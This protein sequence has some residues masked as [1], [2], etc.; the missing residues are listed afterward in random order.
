M[1]EK[2]TELDLAIKCCRSSFI[3]VGIFSLCINLLM[4]VPA[5]YMLQVY[6]R[7]IASGS[8]ST[9]LM[10]TLI[11]V[12]LL[13]TMGILEWVRSSIMQKVSNRLNHQ[14]SPK[15]FDVSYRQALY[16]GGT[17]VSSQPLKDLNGIRQFLSSN[18][19]FAFFDS[20]W[21]PVYIFILYL[22]HPWIGSM[23][24]GSVIILT[25][26]ALLNEKVTQSAQAAANKELTQAANSV[27]KN[28]HNAEV[29]ESMG[30]LSHIR[31]RWSVKNKSAQAF[32][33]LAN[34]R[35]AILSSVSKTF[36]IIIQSLVLGLG[37]YLALQQAIS[38]GMMIAGSILLGRALA[39]IDQMIGV[40]KHF[41]T[42]REQYARLHN[43][44]ETDIGPHEQ[45]SLPEPIGEITAEN[46]VICAPGSRVPILKGLSFYV[47]PG[48]MIGV[49]GPSAAGKSTFARAL[50]GI[51]PALSGKI[52]LDGADIFTWDREELGPHIGYLPQDIELFEGTISDNIARFGKADPK[53]V[54]TA[55]RLAGVHDMILRLPDGYDT[56]ISTQGGTLSGG[57][58]QRIG[59]ARA[60]YGKPKFV[61]LDEPNSNLDH[62]G[63]AALAQTL[64]YL[65]RIRATVF[66]IT[67]RTNVLSL[68]DKLMVLNQGTLTLYGPRDRVIAELNKANAGQISQQNNPSTSDAKEAE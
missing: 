65:K 3:H 51:W 47:A 14:L 60:L 61:V 26:L 33:I 56:Y 54:V 37:A 43:T 27:S 11:M 10:L 42:V 8:E 16:S 62:Q 2:Q 13:T 59:L 39:P 68:V 66:I 7:V 34:E 58:R 32:Q 53:E 4:L 24:L 9:L 31:N 64:K 12:V 46:A 49:I 41:I 38:P 57:Q 23:A 28:L 35:A 18:G 20:P 45:M 6:D 17:L 48:D 63:E 52:R 44:L 1:R 5:L 50:L 55:A 19:L 36:R 30:M 15:M 21:V 67:H 22:F 40:W 25:G 29:I